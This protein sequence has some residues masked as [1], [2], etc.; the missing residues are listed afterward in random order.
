MLVR[1]ALVTEVLRQL[2]DL[3]EPA[4]DQALEVE[5]VGDPQ[6]EVGLELVRVR[7]ERLCEAAAVARLE[8][9]RLDLEEAF[10]VEVGAHGA[11]DPRAHDRE[12]PRVLVHQQVEV[13]APV[14][15]LDVRQAVERV[16]ERGADLGE[17]D[18]LVD[19]ERRLAA[20]RARGRAGDADDVAE[21]EVELTGAALVAEQLDPPRAVDEVEER[22]L[23]HVAPRHHSPGEAELLRRS[24][25]ASSASASARTAAISS[26]SGK[27]FGNMRASLQRPA[28]EAE[29]TRWRHG[30]RRPVRVYAALMSRILYF[31]APRGAETST[32]SPFFFP[33]IAL[34]TGDSFESFSSD[35][36]ASAEP[37]IVYSTVWFG[38]DVLQ[39]HLRA[40]RDD[41]QVDIAGVDHARIGEPL[42][43]RRDLVLEHRLL[44][45]GV[46]VL[47]VLGDVPELARDADAVCDFA[48]PLGRER[49][50]LLLE[51]L[52]AL[53]RENDFLH[54]V[55]PSTKP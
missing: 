55:T 35:G 32:V 22:E 38:A 53:G 3:L 50:D 17:Q 41:A 18:E 29:A 14:A 21:I 7:H 39:P 47:R 51:L 40:D 48:A 52:V 5:L 24:V 30:E 6:V 49:V 28:V 42:L 19:G 16:G 45:L 43:E 26:R 34:P 8:D 23:A 46:V 44:V 1:D 13:P 15:R 54:I 33:M 37:T 27:R 2:V 12:P 9:R 31:R 11:D 25:P 20:P 36:S 4:D 10:A